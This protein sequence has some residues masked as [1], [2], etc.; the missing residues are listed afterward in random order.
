MSLQISIVMVLIV[1]E[2]SEDCAFRPAGMPI[3][4]QAQSKTE[5]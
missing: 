1:K 3:S 5:N 4:K 2:E